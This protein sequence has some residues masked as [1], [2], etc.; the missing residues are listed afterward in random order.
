MS[1]CE[2]ITELR[3]EADFEK[4]PIIAISANAMPSERDRLLELGAT[5]F[6]S[7]PFMKDE[8]YRKIMLA[9]NLPLLTRQPVSAA[10]APKAAPETQ[11]S[12]APKPAAT[13]AEP[14]AATRILVVDDSNANQQLLTSQLKA[15]GFTAE[16][17]A[18]GQIALAKWEIQHYAL[19][20]AD[21]T[22]PVMNGIEMTRRIRAM[23]RADGRGQAPARIIAITGSPEEYR[24]ECIKAGMNEVLGK[25]LLLKALKQAVET[26]L[27]FIA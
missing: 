22:M 8:L 1:G 18:N 16:V 23:E 3:K 4:L 25:P 24:V 10:L 15:L 17:A 6:V 9:L 26:H 21:C 13:A 19:I 12:S 20:F 2:A 7:K 5:D 27:A 14:K 11:A